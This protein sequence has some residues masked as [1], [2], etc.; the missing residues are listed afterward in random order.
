M[1]APNAHLHPSDLPHGFIQPKTGWNA[2]ALSFDDAKRLRRIQALQR[3]T[4]DW[5]GLITKGTHPPADW[6]RSLKLKS[7]LR[8]PAA[9]VLQSSFLED[10][11]QLEK[12][13]LDERPAEDTLLRLHE[14][15]WRVQEITLESLVSQVPPESILKISEQAGL[16][17][18][19]RKRAPSVSNRQE[20]DLADLYA[21]FNSDLLWIGAHPRQIR[22]L[23]GYFLLRRLR[24]TRL[25][26]NLIDPTFLQLD[27]KETRSSIALRDYH[28]TWLQGWVRGWSAGQFQ[29]QIQSPSQFP[30]RLDIQ[31]APPLT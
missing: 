29:L 17:E 14:L 28:L 15:C 30:I 31:V 20:L 3:L 18:A 1:E 4:E 23:A 2:R 6:I 13:L 7:E 27:E 12:K 5:I 9:H 10:E 16:R 25:E 11:A 24:K 22:P 26:L 21:E 8:F 19:E